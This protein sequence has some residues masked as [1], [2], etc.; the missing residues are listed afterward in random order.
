MTPVS[1]LKAAALALT[2]VAALATSAMADIKIGS[3][4][5]QTGPASFL[6]DPEAKT[7]QML[8]DAQNAKG[9]VN[10]EKIELVIY[11]DAADPN[12]AKTFATRLVPE[13]D[14]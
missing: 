6:G 9:G 13:S 2:A 14:R 4:L 1:T 10:G 3:T 5:A 7:L 11:D 8:V 12:Q